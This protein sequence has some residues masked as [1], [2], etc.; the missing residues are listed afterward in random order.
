M[1]EAGFIILGTICSCLLA[2][3]LYLKA[4]L[5]KARKNSAGLYEQREELR[6]RW[7]SERDDRLV[8][9]KQREGVTAQ[10]FELRRGMAKLLGK[11]DL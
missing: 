9:Y 6:R 7:E 3:V 11:E 5:K 4:E 2:D 8:L 10:Y 1:V